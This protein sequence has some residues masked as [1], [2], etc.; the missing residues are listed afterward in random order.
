MMEQ[1]ST[2]N[3]RTVPIFD[4]I[5]DDKHKRY[6]DVYTEEPTLCWGLGVEN[7]C[8]LLLNKAPE[9]VKEF[10]QL[11]LKSERYSVNYFNNFKSDPL[12]AT[13][14]KLYTCAKLTYP[15]YINSHTFDKMDPQLKHRTT[16]EHEPKPTPGFTESLHEILLRE[17]E[18]YRT[19]SGVS[20]VFDGDSIEFIT[21]KFYN[22]TVSNCIHELV[23]LKQSFLSEV[24][25]F[26]E[27]WGIGSITFPSHNYGLAT[28]L[29]T[30]TK[31]LAVCNNATYHINMT[32]PAFIQ[33]GSLVNKPAFIQQHL[34]F[35][36]C[37]QMVEPL[38]VA[39]YG[40]PDVFSVVDPT[41]SRNYSL[42][43]LRVTLSRY[44]SLQTFDTNHP[45]NGKLLLMN[46]SSDPSWWYHQLDG[47]SYQMN[48]QI[49]ADINFNKFKNHGVEIRFLDWF[50]E[51]YLEEL[52]NFFVLLAQHSV[53][54]GSCTFD[55][56]RYQKIT[57][58]CV[59]KGFTHILST[60]D[61]N[62]I[63][64]DL[65]LDDVSAHMTAFDLLSHI[66]Y[67]LYK[68]Y[69]TAPIV[70]Q[71]APGMVCP[72]LVNYNWI[73]F[74]ELYH[75]VHGRPDLILRSEDN[76]LESRTTIIPD[77]IPLLQSHYNVLVESSPNRCFSD[78]EYQKKGATIVPAGHWESSHH[79]YVIGLKGIRHFAKKQQ[80]HMHFAHCFK[81]QINSPTVL[82]RIA[83]SIFIDYEFM[84]DDEKK[85][86]ISF[87]K[88]SGKIG[89][90]LALM[91]YYKKLQKADKMN[92][93]T[94]PPFDETVYH[95]ELST[96]VKWHKP[97]V[98]LIGFGMVGKAC[99]AVLDQFDIDCTIWTTATNPKPKDS[100][101][102]H[103]ILLHATSLRE[104]TY[105]P[106]L[107]QSDLQAMKIVHKP[108]DLYDPVHLSVICDISCD[109]GN[110]RNLLPIYDAYTS[111]EQPI[112]SLPCQPSIDLIAIPYLP[113]LEPIVSSVEF[114]STLIS[115][116]CE[117]LYFHHTRHIH[118]KA[119]I[120]YTSY[121]LF[122]NM[123]Q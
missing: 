39:C 72:Q 62:L 99:K 121:E 77:H 30:G 83:P 56:V 95:R 115:Y 110:P 65:Q 61:C 53:S 16:Y 97:K 103:D 51:E 20:T 40:T 7:E 70:Q 113:A 79:S 86:V 76:P 49:G 24:S 81:G 71:M 43:S 93:T 102:Q 101:M 112:I 27:Q 9:T 100:I 31:N 2:I 50:P 12:V 89:C 25:P 116:L 23:T 36:R 18:Y 47:S 22:A 118:E 106:F 57:L 8:Y 19:I 35:V 68:K 38:I 96:L 63:L 108:A 80:T 59:T 29:S 122:C 94:I 37:I 74:Q 64:Q 92:T 107:L 84:I 34:E 45:V 114:S 67:V 88:Q 13:I 54:I 104:I 11:K 105:D 5:I 46:K 21:Q 41:D 14:K 91:T 60:E 1:H 3:L 117:L 17:S 42:G 69:S 6:T 120:L 119:E 26:F 85:R 98:L 111:K 109:L 33:N 58:S 73:A 78:E 10:T 90:Y 4:D 66:C 52:M 28:F 44:I 32:L 48:E 15:T 123:I 87:C 55:R 75:D 82:S